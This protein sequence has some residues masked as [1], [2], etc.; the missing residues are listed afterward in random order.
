[1]S[2]KVL[3]LLNKSTSSVL[4]N[5]YSIKINQFSSSS[6]NRFS[7]I[8]S[9]K[10]NDEVKLAQEAKPSQDTIFGKISRKEIPANIIFEDEQVSCHL[11]LLFNE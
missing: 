11:N 7:D 3:K 5:Y 10:M 4:L 6:F 9:K 2:L 1:M 8:N